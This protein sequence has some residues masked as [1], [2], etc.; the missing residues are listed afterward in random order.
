MFNGL[1]YCL[2]AIGLVRNRSMMDRFRQPL[3]EAR[4]AMDEKDQRRFFAVRDTILKSV[5]AELRNAREE[6]I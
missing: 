5:E 2:S 1:E 3:K 6:F 4:D